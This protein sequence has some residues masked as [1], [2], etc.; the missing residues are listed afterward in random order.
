MLGNRQK[1]KKK[2]GL[3]KIFTVFFSQNCR[4]VSY[5]ETN[6]NQQAKQ[7]NKIIF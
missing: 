5:N 6:K 7:M 4:V 2:E 1:R 3:N